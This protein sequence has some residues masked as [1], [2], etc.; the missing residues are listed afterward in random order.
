M[1]RSL[2]LARLAASSFIRSF[3]SRSSALASKAWNAA[4]A[5]ATGSTTA[6]ATSGGAQGGTTPQTGDSTAT[7]RVFVKPMILWLWIGGLIMA[8]GTLLA[9]FPGSRRRRAI[10][11]V[12]APTAEPDREPAPSP[13]PD[14]DG[15]TVPV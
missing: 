7:I 2:I 9:A 12:S 1:S 6:S 10:D 15:E 4:T 5:T 8:I 13:A 11:P 14:V 3:W